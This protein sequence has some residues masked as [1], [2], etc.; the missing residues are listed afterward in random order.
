MFVRAAP[1]D[2]GLIEETLLAKDVDKNLLD[3][4][5]R[6][7]KEKSSRLTSGSPSR[8][9]DRLNVG[10][11]PPKPLSKSKLHSLMQHVAVLANKSPATSLRIS[12]TSP[13]SS[14]SLQDWSTDPYKNGVNSFRFVTWW[15]IFNVNPLTKYEVVARIYQQIAETNRH[16]ASNVVF[17]RFHFSF[18]GATFYTGT[19]TVGWQ[20]ANPSTYRPAIAAKKS[21]SRYIN[22]VVCNRN[23]QLGEA[24][25]PYDE[26]GQAFPL[27]EE[28]P[29]HVMQID[30][31]ALAGGAYGTDRTS[32]NGDSEL[33]FNAPV[34]SH[35][36]GHFFGM[37][38]TFQDDG[39]CP[40]YGGSEHDNDAYVKVFDTPTQELPY[41]STEDC[42]NNH[43]DCDD[44]D[45]YDL[46]NIMGHALCAG[47][48]T[49][50]Q[51]N[52]MGQFAVEY[53][54]RLL[55]RQDCET[56]PCLTNGV[57]DPNL[58]CT[59][60]KIGLLVGTSGTRLLRIGKQCCHHIAG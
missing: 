40:A 49:R 21:P 38:H 7:A 34:F 26:K 13:F 32:T 52:Y 6:T 16:F 33:D 54:T 28:D 11:S 27:Q 60:P 20:C 4:A 1:S 8:E 12:D 23:D 41:P 37:L 36:L 44:D 59:E 14:P 24:S 9:V 18:G 5:M 17:Y 51:N 48:F 10:Q 56:N 30:P 55:S 19:E 50:D 35:L 47:S 43:F 22:T 2:L 29:R 45:P 15:H 53:H 39:K 46:G 57:Y 25:F 42:S 31:E 58:V 3:E